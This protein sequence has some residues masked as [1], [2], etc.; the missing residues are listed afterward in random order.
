MR[1]TTFA[2][3]IVQDNFKKRLR[4]FRLGFIMKVGRVHFWS[5]QARTL[6]A[7]NIGLILGRFSSQE[8][9]CLL[10]TW[11]MDDFTLSGAFN[12]TKSARAYRC[13]VED[14]R[15]YFRERSY[16]T[17]SACAYLG[18]LELGRLYRQRPSWWL[19]DLLLAGVD[20]FLGAL[21][22]AYWTSK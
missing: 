13:D 3:D 7:V 21:C 6:A 17:N 1:L 16:L 2:I 9:A 14:R 8:S 20:V 18:D 12:R 5:R 10:A 19:L 11:N 22:L 15:P 4:L